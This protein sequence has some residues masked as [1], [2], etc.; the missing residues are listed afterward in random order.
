MAVRRMS[1]LCR[2]EMNKL[3]GIIH[4]SWTRMHINTYMDIIWYIH[5]NKN[6]Y[7]CTRAFVCIYIYIYIYIY[8][9]LKY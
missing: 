8:I 2:I 6:I 3:T 5:I 7:I 1:D 4:R 9:F